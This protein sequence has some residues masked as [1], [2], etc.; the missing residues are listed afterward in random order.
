MT[1][2]RKVFSAVVV[3]AAF[4]VGGFGL[5]VLTAGSLTA[6]TT[7]GVTFDALITLVGAVL[8]WVVFGYLALG[9]V[10]ALLAALPGA[11]GAAFDS[12]SERVT[13]R[14][15]RRVVQLVLGLT[16]VAGP[17]IGTAA[18][19]APND[20]TTSITAVAGRVN[21]D[22]PG[23]S[24]ANAAS[25]I[26]LERPGDPSNNGGSRVDLD[27]PGTGAVDT[28]A[29][30]SARPNAHDL[31]VKPVRDR[32]D[33]SYTVV[34]GDCLWDIAKAHLPAGATDSQIDAEWHRWYAA[35][36]STVGTNPDL[37]LPGQVFTPPPST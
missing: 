1:V 31:L 34:R 10:L 29:P 26:E 33:R 24:P 15:Y 21:L 25:R 19:A 6:V 16:V 30:G 17:A 18:Q 28:K 37:I 27:R 4:V 36:R 13:P 12:I 14:A 8:A 35:N 7:P 5:S 9:A 20:V 32:A 3:V 23:E 22:R 11:A 2:V